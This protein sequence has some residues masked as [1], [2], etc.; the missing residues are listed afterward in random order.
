M[1]SVID[2]VLSALIKQNKVKLLYTFGEASD[3]HLLDCSPNDVPKLIKAGK[4]NFY[5]NPLKTGISTRN[6]K[7]PIW[8]IID[9]ISKNTRGNKEAVDL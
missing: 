8:E 6:K 7:I 3:E 2:G 4:L 5:S 9:H 1:D